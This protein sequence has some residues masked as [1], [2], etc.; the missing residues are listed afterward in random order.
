MRVPR[1]LTRRPARPE[2]PPVDTLQDGEAGA[3][4]Y[5]LGEHILLLEGRLRA[6]EAGQDRAEALMKKG[7][8][9]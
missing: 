8:E 7:G 6:I 5:A 9:P 4:I 1:D 3:L 2:L